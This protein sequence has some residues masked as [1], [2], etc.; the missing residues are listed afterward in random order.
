MKPDHRRSVSAVNL[1]VFFWGITPV[2]VKAS[3]ATSSAILAFRLVIS[4]PIAIALFFREGSKLSWLGFRNAIVPALFFYISTGSGYAAFQQTSIAN[5]MLISQLAPVIVLFAAPILF[6]ESL[7]WKRVSL[8]TLSLGGAALVIIGGEHA[9]TSTIT[10]DLWAGV[11]CITW[12]IY[13]LIVKKQ[14]SSGTRVWEFLTPVMLW[15]AVFAILGA[16]LLE[17]SLSIPRFFDWSMVFSVGIL[18]LSAHALLTWAQ[19]RLEAITT[20]LLMLGMPIVS[21]LS[22]LLVFGEALSVLQSVGGVTVIC[23]LALVTKV[24]SQVTEKQAIASDHD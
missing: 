13:F 4:V 9:G 22:A 11:N 10:G 12:A 8:A 14:R 6:K 5:A 17:Q 23:A 19:S 15:S 24:S 20:S 1:A 2:F 3:D 21:T 16:L 7:E 18:S